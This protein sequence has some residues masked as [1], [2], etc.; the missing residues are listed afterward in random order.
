MGTAWRTYGFVIKILAR[1]PAA[2]IALM[3][4]VAMCALLGTLDN[5]SVVVRHG[6]WQQAVQENVSRSTAWLITAAK[7]HFPPNEIASTKYALHLDELRLT[8][9]A[10]PISWDSATEAARIAFGGLTTPGSFLFLAMIVSW[11]AGASVAAERQ[12]GT[13]RTLVSRPGGRWA[14]L[15]GKLLV[16]LMMSVVLLLAAWMTVFGVLGWRDGGWNG[17][18]QQVLVARQL[19]PLIPANLS[20][21]RGWEYVLGYILV[22]LPS[23]VFFIALAMIP[24]VLSR[25]VAD[26]VL[27][28]MGAAIVLVLVPHILNMSGSGGWLALTPLSHLSA[29]N[30]LVSPGPPR[31]GWVFGM[32]TYGI[33]AA[34]SST[35]LMLGWDGVLFLGAG[36]LFVKSDI[37]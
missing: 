28:S 18:N 13:L 16:V 8:Y 37:W 33:N 22:L 20:V 27:V 30:L 15:A 1:S 26:A 23:M 5:G 19:G 32:P 4:T 25:R 12:D 17:L 6:A 11:M 24:S 7:Y 36:M 14:I 9:G 34:W 21:M 3:C 35:M 2:R 29:E 31:P 10:A